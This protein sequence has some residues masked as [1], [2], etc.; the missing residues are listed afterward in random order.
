M[1]PAT[2]LKNARLLDPWTHLDQ[3]GDLLI[4]NGQMTAIG[5]DAART[6]PD[7][8]IVINCDGYCLAPGL[9]DMRAHLNEPGRE[10]IETLATLSQ[11]A[12]AG[13]I[14]TL[15]GLPDTDPVLDDVALIDFITRRARKV[16]LVHLYA[17][18]A[19]TKG[20][21][22]KELTEF[23]LMASAGALGFTD[24]NRAVGDA[25]LM[26]RALSYARTFDQ[27]I[28]QH[29]L[30]PSLCDA[31]SATEGEFATRLGL[32][33]MPALAEQIQIERDVHLV[34]LTGARY[35]AAHISTAGA[36]NAIRRAKQRGLP[37]SC[38]T[39]PAYFMLNE[40]AIGSYDTLA[41][42][43]PPLRCE[44]D[45]KAVL[46]GLLDGTID[47][48][49]SDHRP[50]DL[51]TKHLPYAAASAGAIGLETLLPLALGLHHAH[52]MPLLKAVNLITKA[53]ADILRLPAG[54]LA[55]G[56]VADLVLFDPDRPWR[57]DASK[58]IS[59]TPN[60]PFHGMP[61]QGQVLISIVAGR[62]T[63]RR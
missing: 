33:G 57:V 30:E 26:R 63:F 62:I 21:A 42:L 47:A 22:G 1:M 61:V 4:I 18:G 38:D 3:I 37:V 51:D 28:I 48:I 58:F 46:D 60:T 2:L 43:S 41:K 39:A 45:R 5:A 56:A 35:H 29:P 14:T 44:A 53:P 13:G 23:G 27:L 34:E 7:D 6:V 12:A 25:L 52:N 40:L 16:G 24:P 15:V 11:A 50:L 55:I 20:L 31:G 17:Y 36:I 19:L 32:P 10:H 59:K 8:A 49:V 54:R 9:V